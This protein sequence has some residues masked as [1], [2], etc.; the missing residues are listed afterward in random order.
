MILDG[1]RFGAEVKAARV[2]V[3][4]NFSARQAHFES[5]TGLVN[6]ASLKAGG[7]A[8]LTRA[9]FAGPVTFQSGHIGENWSL[10]GSLFTNASA[11]AKFEEVKVDGAR[12][13]NCTTPK[14][15]SQKEDQVLTNVW[16]RI[17]TILGWA[18]IPI[19]L[20]AWTG[21]LSH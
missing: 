11:L 6:F 16:R 13:S 7:D 14:S 21:M 20:A 10:D 4:G 9:T 18:L 19:A 3:M 17:H 2:E 1:A 8:Q 15:G 5:S 12:S